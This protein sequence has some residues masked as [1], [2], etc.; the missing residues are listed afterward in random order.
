MS[1]PL[2]VATVSDRPFVPLT[3]AIN[4]SVIADVGSVPVL[5]MLPLTAAKIVAQP[6]LVSDSNR[7]ATELIHRKSNVTATM[8][9]P[10]AELKLAPLLEDPLARTSTTTSTNVESLAVAKTSPLNRADFSTIGPTPIAA[11]VSDSGFSKWLSRVSLA[12]QVNLS[13]A[14]AE[15]RIE[16][17]TSIVPTTASIPRQTK[18]ST[19]AA[20]TEEVKPIDP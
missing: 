6:S 11:F 20:I 8:L 4:R 9:K 12:Q 14:V 10:A 17:A 2:S 5:A 19:A 13:Q 16:P 18:E 3:M 1:S 7:A 15:T